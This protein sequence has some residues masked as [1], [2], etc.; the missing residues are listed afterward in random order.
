MAKVAK[1]HL[2]ISMGK[3]SMSK[4]YDRQVE[5]QPFFMPNFVLLKLFQIKIK[6]I[7]KV[8]AMVNA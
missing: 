2:G 4:E 1:N 5:Y 7:L 6:C 3:I 8:V